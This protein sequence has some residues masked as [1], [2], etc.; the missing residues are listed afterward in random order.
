MKLAEPGD[1]VVIFADDV[2][3]TWKQV[4]YWGRPESEHNF[5]AADV[6]RA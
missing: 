3:R 1:L 2:T 5:G 4:I 6:E